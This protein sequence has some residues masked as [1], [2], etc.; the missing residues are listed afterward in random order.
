MMRS[1]GAVL[2]GYAVFWLGNALVFVITGKDPRAENPLEFVLLWLGNGMLCGLL[3]GLV[4]GWLT[5]RAYGL[6]GLAVGACIAAGAAVTMTVDPV[7]ATQFLQWVTIIVF[8][9]LAW[10][11]AAIWGRGQR[12]RDQRASVADTGAQVRRVESETS[13]L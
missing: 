12:L 13:S 5:R 9:P 4:A 2:A 11:G 1:V 7:G 10:L 3:A 6:H 8:A